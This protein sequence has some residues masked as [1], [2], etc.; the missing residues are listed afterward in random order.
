MEIAEELGIPT[1][2]TIPKGCK[3]EDGYD[4]DLLERF[5]LIESYSS[6]YAV[7]TRANALHSDG[8]ILFLDNDKS[9]GTKCTKK[10]L[11]DFNKPFYVVR[12][13]M[14][15]EISDAFISEVVNWIIDNDVKVLNVA[16]NRE[17]K[18][19]GIAFVVRNFMR[20]VLQKMQNINSK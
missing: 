19:P 3:T 6:D 8:T 2:G 4:R 5:N 18:S 15:Q 14:G 1:G 7:R 20:K 10:A 12:V 11:K 9:P 13:K 16:G 17:S